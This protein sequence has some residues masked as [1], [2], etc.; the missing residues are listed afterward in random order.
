MPNQLHQTLDEAIANAPLEPAGAYCEVKP[1]G[2][3]ETK[4]AVLRAMVRRAIDA[5]LRIEILADEPTLVD[6]LMSGLREFEE[7]AIY[8]VPAD[9]PGY[10]RIKVCRPVRL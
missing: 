7:A 3:P 10:F 5:G 4:R 9:Q 1:G 2:P 6:A 8:S